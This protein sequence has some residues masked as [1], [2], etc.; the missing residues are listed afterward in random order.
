MKRRRFFGVLAA[1]PLMRLAKR[2]V[3]KGGKVEIKIVGRPVVPFTG[4]I[5]FDMKFDDN[6]AE[7]V[8]LRF[9]RDL[10][11]YSLTGKLPAA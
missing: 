9:E 2:R 7:R 1:L 8:F 11:Q 3:F 4:P 6:E 10:E 5:K